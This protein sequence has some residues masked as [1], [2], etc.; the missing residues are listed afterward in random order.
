MATYA[1]VRRMRFRDGLSISEIARR[2]SLARNTI[3]AWLREPVRGAMSFRRPVG[4]KKIDEHVQWLH[5]ALEADAHRARSDRRTALKLHQQLQERGFTGGY[6]RVTEA[7][8]AWR[9]QKQ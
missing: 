3:K 5:Q 4:P 8:R 1:K 9:A 7:V 6:A 2:T